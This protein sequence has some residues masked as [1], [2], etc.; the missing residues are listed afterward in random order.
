[1]KHG[2]VGISLD[3]VRSRAYGAPASYRFPCYWGQ[4]DCTLSRRRI[5]L[6]LAS[7]LRVWQLLFSA[8]KAASAA[9]AAPTRVVASVLH[10]SWPL[11]AS[12][13]RSMKSGP[14][15]RR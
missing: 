5:L 1:M 12:A 14:P 9:A 8:S 7:S 10:R 6:C 11:S 15:L 3:E 13:T 2:E 4:S